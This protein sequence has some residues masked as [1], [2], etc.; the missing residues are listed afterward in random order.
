[1][2]SPA[3]PP[4][5]VHADRRA[6]FAERLEG[7]GIV[8]ALISQPQDVAYLTGAAQ[9]CNLLV[10]PGREPTLFARRFGTLVRAQAQIDR[11][12][13]G[14]GFGDVAQELSRLGVARGALG[15]ELDVIPA[16][17]FGKVVAR[18]P[19]FDVVDCAALLLKQRAVKDSYEI[20]SLRRSAGLFDAVQ[21][22]MAAFLRPGIAEHELA[23]EVQRALR[24]AGHAGLV[25]QR[26]WDAALQPEGGIASGPNLT[27]MSGG[28]V[29]ISGVGTS[30][31]VPHGASRRRIEDGDLV[32]IDLGMNLD[33][34]HADMA[35]TY[36]VREA[37]DALLEWTIATRRC[38]DAVLAAIR[39]G[40]TA[41]EVYAAGRD[42]AD[43]LRV[44]DAF[45]GWGGTYGPYVG[46]G[47][48]LELDEPPV[49]GPGAG[50]VLAER[51]VLA[52]EIK[53]MSPRSGRST[54]RTTWLSPPRDARSSA[55][56]R[57]RRS[58]ST[59]PAAWSPCP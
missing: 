36:A 29:T 19:A 32:N 21:E 34:Y 53:L 39:P 43:A 17:L 18:F 51:M 37:P 11:I 7:A 59:T 25:A 58:R 33:G 40:A 46:H 13:D 30:P 35:R 9:P 16:A 47:I 1:M 20:E 56:R 44:G 31:A 27:V 2:R 3:G 6:A 38:Q 24:R 26:R 14:G 4:T 10:V 23:G 48:G 8:A 22:T 42:A 55:I 52:V 15:L 45:Q 50:D 49:L 12:V 41:G 57:G 5:H 28:P 54:S